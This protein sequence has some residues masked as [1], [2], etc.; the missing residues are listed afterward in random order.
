M[1]YDLSIFIP[2]FR[3]PLWPKVYE[4]AKKACKNYNWEMVFIGPFEPPE[5]L[6][7][8][9]NVLFI[10]D[11][12]CVTRCAQLGML[13]IR[14]DLFF[15]TVDDCIFAE[16]AIDLAMKKYEEECGYKD[17]VSM[18]YGEGGNKMDTSYWTVQN[19]NDFTCLPGV[20]NSWRLAN[21]CIMNKNYFIELGGLDCI[22]FEYIDKPIH[23][24]MF[25][26]Q[27]DGGKIVF[28][29]EHTCIATWYPEETGDHAPIHNAMNQRD[30]P[31]FNR[32]YSDPNYYLNRLK[33]EY[34]N[35][36]KSPEV[37]KRRF[38]KGIPASYEELCKQEGYEV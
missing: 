13:E 35:W 23:D 27:K 31:T 34:D 37:W 6:K 36:K 32:M 22:N 18:I 12:G 17:V 9:E 30:I 24:F 10:K 16:D 3:T 2:A 15:L 33:I 28:A 38:S 7:K 11:Y 26:L 25:R 5:E 21:Q 29:P 14:S 20:D 1:K 4:S 8:E 19:W